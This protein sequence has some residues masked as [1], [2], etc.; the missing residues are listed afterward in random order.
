MHICAYGD[1][2]VKDFYSASGGLDFDFYSMHK[3]NVVRGFDSGL[4]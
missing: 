3:E 2:R 4:F 1:E